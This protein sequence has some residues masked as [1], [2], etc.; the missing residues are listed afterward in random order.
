M[1]AFIDAHRDAYGVEP[2]CAELPI[3]PATYYTHKA[4]QNDPSRRPARAVRDAWLKHEIRRVR[5]LCA[6][7]HEGWLEDHGYLNMDYWKEQKKDLMRV[8]A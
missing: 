4:C 5:A 7:T 2:I 3:A 8:A 6:E 1:A